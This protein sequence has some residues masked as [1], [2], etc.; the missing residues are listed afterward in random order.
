MNYG[1][2]VEG[3]RK[4]SELIRISKQFINFAH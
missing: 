3:K 4:K 2:K 1:F